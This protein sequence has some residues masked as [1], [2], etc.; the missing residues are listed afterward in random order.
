MDRQ[1]TKEA[2]EKSTT[3]TALAEL[4]AQ[5]Q[6]MPESAQKRRLINKLNDANGQG[7]PSLSSKKR[8]RLKNLLTPKGGAVKINAGKKEGSYKIGKKFSEDEVAVTPSYKRQDSRGNSAMVTF[9]DA[10]ASASKPGM[11]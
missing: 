1:K 11:K 7:T 5:V 4:Y 3:E 2:Q 6:A 9:S 8:P 10:Q